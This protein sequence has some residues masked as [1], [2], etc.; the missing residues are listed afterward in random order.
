MVFGQNRRSRPKNDAPSSSSH[1]KKDRI[2]QRSRERDIDS[3]TR[4]KRGEE[5]G[6]VWG[7][8]P[9]ISLLENDPRRCLKVL[10]SSTVNKTTFQKITDLCK[11][12]AIQFVMTDAR[13]LDELT[14]GENH[15]GVAAQVS[16]TELAAYQELLARISKCDTSIAVMLDHIQDPHNL[17][18][19]IRTAEAVGAH[20]AALPSRRSSLPTGI[21][22]K[23]S[24]GASLRLPIAMIGNVGAAL[25]DAKEAGC[26]CVG[27]DADAETNIF[28]TKLPEKTM[29]VV[30][31]EGKGLSRTAASE[32]DELVS[33]PITGKVGSLNASIA[34][35]VAAFEWARQNRTDKK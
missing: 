15:Q 7:R 35:A 1:A 20:F 23:T 25:R 34:S 2:G 19:I 21:V 3:D 22:A 29:L 13:A 12:C 18:A 8:G 32:C 6:S 24:A 28:E 30:G 4:G 33:I 31:S 14:G 17:G 26:W 16:P 27:L 11:E 5:N 10:L 9:V